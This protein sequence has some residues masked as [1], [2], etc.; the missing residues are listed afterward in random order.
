MLFDKCGELVEGGRKMSGMRSLRERPWAASNWSHC[1]RII[2][3]I[4]ARRTWFLLSI[5]DDV[6]VLLWGFLVNNLNSLNLESLESIDVP[7]TR[8]TAARE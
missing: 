4:S 5:D 2:R 1:L 7:G 6:P 8:T 3:I